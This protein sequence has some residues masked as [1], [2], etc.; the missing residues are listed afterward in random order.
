M[1]AD[2]EKWLAE[3]AA[4]VQ[5]E[6]RFASELVGRLEGLPD[7]ATVGEHITDDEAEAL[8]KRISDEE[9][10]PVDRAKQWFSLSPEQ[11]RPLLKKAADLRGWSRET[12]RRL[13]LLDA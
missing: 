6:A 1:K 3:L 10:I 2:D 8:F 5:V 4:Q 7:N 13:G 11:R 12:R 9:R